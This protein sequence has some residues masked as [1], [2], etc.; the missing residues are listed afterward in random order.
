MLSF[1]GEV[2]RVQNPQCLRGS[3]L[4]KESLELFWLFKS[5]FSRSYW[6]KVLLGLG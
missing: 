3:V 2:L 1:S 5:I 6:T 4:S